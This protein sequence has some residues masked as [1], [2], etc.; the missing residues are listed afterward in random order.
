MVEETGQVEERRNN[1]GM[2]D[3]TGKGGDR[4]G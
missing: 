1:V 2:V 4:M 3:G